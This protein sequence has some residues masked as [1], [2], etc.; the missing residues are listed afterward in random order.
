[1]S[2]CTL[3]QLKFPKK[4][5]SKAVIKAV[6]Q[7]KGNVPKVGLATLKKTMIRNPVD[8]PLIVRK[9]GGGTA[10]GRFDG[11][12]AHKYRLREDGSGKPHKGI[13]LKGNIGDNVYALA[14]G[15]VDYIEDKDTYIKGKKGGELGKYVQ[16]NHGGNIYSRY[17]HL[18]KISVKKG[19]KIT[20]SDSNDQ[21]KIGEIGKTGNVGGEAHL[22]LEVF[23]Y[24]PKKQKWGNRNFYDPAKI[25]QFTREE[26]LTETKK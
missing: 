10:D 14:C 6:T 8:T 22:H 13:D 25:F 18:S 19:E 17:G 5:S 21:K 26:K 2:K 20:F 3:I 11:K 7:P 9:K 24:D 1:M 16:I 23:T 15:K 4:T 12:G